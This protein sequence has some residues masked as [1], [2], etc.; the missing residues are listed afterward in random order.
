MEIV[1]SFQENQSI[2]ILLAGIKT[3]GLGLN[4]TAADYCFILDPWWNPAIEDQAI[5]RAH[6]LGQ[7]SEVFITRFTS[8]G[9]VEE[10]IAAVLDRKRQIFEEMLSQNGP[11]SS[12]G[13]SEKDIFGLFN[14]KARPKRMA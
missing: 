4:L 7:K 2:S 9:T 1:A 13:L 3:G 6:R 12:L 8:T 10:R 14:I 11:P 5:N